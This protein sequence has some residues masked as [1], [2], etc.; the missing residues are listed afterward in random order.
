M[1]LAAGGG[2]TVAVTP[3]A[4]VAAVSG[5]Q[6]NSDLLAQL[7]QKKQECTEKDMKIQEQE[8]RIAD[9]ITEIETVRAELKSMRKDM[10]K[11]AK[12]YAN[13]QEKLKQLDEFEKTKKL[14]QAVARYVSCFKI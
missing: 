11:M 4:A 14:L 12:Q 1:Q 8:Q 2:S 10:L 7:E 5:S 13:Q 3:V 6:D 9:K